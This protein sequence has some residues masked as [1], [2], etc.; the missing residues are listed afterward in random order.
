MDITRRRLL[1]LLPAAAVAWQ[2][3]DLLDETARRLEEG[4]V[5][6]VDDVRSVAGPLV[7]Y[8]AEVRRLKS[9]LGADG[10]GYIVAP[11]HNLQAITPIEN[12]LA[13]YEAVQN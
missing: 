12:I 9:I 8:S 10:T 2:V 3:T 11:C 1:M 6:S 5:R 4:K 7:G 13:L